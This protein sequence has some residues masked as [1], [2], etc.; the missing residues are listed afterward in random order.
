MKTKEELNTLKEEVEKLGEKLKELSE[1][2]FKEVTGGTGRL[3][4]QGVTL[5]PEE[6]KSE[7]FKLEA[8]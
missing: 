7:F 1:D 2:E 3:S 5:A 4:L 6:A 8:R